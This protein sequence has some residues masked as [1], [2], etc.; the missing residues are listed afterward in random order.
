MFLPGWIKLSL[1]WLKLFA[2]DL[3]RAL[4]ATDFVAKILI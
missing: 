3:V 4:M 2:R 1:N